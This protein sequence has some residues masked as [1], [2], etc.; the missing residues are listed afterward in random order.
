MDQETA[1]AIQEI[2]PVDGPV[3]NFRFIGNVG[4]LFEALAKAQAEFTE[5]DRDAQVSFD[6]R[7]FKYATLAE[8]LSSVRPALNKHGIALLQP[9]DGDHVVTML[10]HGAARFEVSAPLPPWKGVQD[11]GSALTY[12]KRY[13][14]KSMLGVND[15]EDDDGNESQGTGKTPEPRNRA[16]PP[17]TKPAGPPKSDI[18]PSTRSK[19]VE[20]A[21]SAG[22]QK[23]DLEAF[24]AKQ[25]LGNTL[26]SLTEFNGAKLVVALEALRVQG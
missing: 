25:D 23:V 17:A 1:P 4:P 12:I 2:G 21:K 5:M 24:I 11:L 7:M 13:Q 16:T 6:K 9:F 14:V 20:L 3:T 15:G 26:D 18:A 22:F 10:C 19:I 8:V